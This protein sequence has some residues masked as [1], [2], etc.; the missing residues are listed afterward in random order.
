MLQILFLE[1]IAVLNSRICLVILLYNG[2][3]CKY[4]SYN[5]FESNESNSKLY[6]NSFCLTLWKP[7]CLYISRDT[8]IDG[9]WNLISKL[10]QSPHM[11][12]VVEMGIFYDILIKL[13]NLYVFMQQYERDMASNEFCLAP[14]NCYGGRESPEYHLVC[15]QVNMNVLV[16]VITA[17]HS[18]GVG[19][20]LGMFLK[21]AKNVCLPQFPSSL[22]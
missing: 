18:T 12:S 1:C 7:K 15:M 22:V 4:F 9:C 14:L 11:Y 8:A 20:S 6:S 16:W 3:C 21:G 17:C 13:F 19:I 5:L 2:Q 10:S